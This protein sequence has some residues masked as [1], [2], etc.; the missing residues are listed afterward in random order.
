MP[1][2]NRTGPNGMGPMTGRGAGYCAGYGSPGYVS[3][4]AGRGLGRG[5]GFGPGRGG[6]YGAGRGRRLGFYATGAPGW[7]R[8]GANP[9]VQPPDPGPEFTK[10]ALQN[11]ADA[12][13]SE[14]ELVRK[15]LDELENE[16]S[17][18]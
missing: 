7:I 11:Q 17:P 16:R 1:A 2:G 18:E 14:L 13:T 5:G 15:R 10:Q 12:L 6:G 8:Y 9:G 4:G 3:P